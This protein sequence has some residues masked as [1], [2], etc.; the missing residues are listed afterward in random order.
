MSTQPAP[1]AMSAPVDE[2]VS[3]F[4][5]TW[6]PVVAALGAAL[7]GW[8]KRIR[9]KVK[10]EHLD[11]ELDRKTLN[12]LVDAVDKL[13]RQQ[14]PIDGWQPDGAELYRQAVLILSVREERWRAAGNTSEISA[15][16]LERLLSR[17]HSRTMRI[18][19]KN[20]RKAGEES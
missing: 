11:R 19:L 13:L 20:E 9:A 1:Q 18:Q 15:E 3:S 10:K 4:V 5:K 8:L 6:W 2:T 14:N 12:Y 16:K 17:V 7:W